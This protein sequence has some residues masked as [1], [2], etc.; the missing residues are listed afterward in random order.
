MPSKSWGN[1]ELQ[2]LYD[3]SDR[4][5]TILRVEDRR[6]GGSQ[7]MPLATRGGCSWLVFGTTADM[8]FRFEESKL[9]RKRKGSGRNIISDT[10]DED[11]ESRSQSRSPSRSPSR[12]RRQSFAVSSSPSQSQQVASDEEDDQP[13]ALLKRKLPKRSDAK[14]SELPEPNEVIIIDDDE[15]DVKQVGAFVRGHVQGFQCMQHV[16]AE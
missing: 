5:D 13:I 7:T 8:K 2:L 3:D 14:R 6:T 10:S 1:G 12:S 15:A 4:S 16:K 11:L 9:K